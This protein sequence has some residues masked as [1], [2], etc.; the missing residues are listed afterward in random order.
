MRRSP[1]GADERCTT[2][3]LQGMTSS[4][5][6]W[7]V[8]GA[9][10]KTARVE[11][12][13]VR[14]IERAFPLWRDPSRLSSVL[15]EIARGLG[16]APV[17]A[18]TMTAE[19]ADCYATK[20]EGVAAVLDAFRSAFPDIEPWIYGVDGRFRS[21][22]AA[23]A[24]PLD[25]AAANWMASATLVARSFPD[26]IFIDVGST[27]TDVIPIFRGRVVAEG[28][29]DPARLRTGELIYTGALRTPV[30]AIARSVPVDGHRYR[31]AAEL[32]AVAADVHLWLGHIEERDYTCDTPD[33]RGRSRAE[34]AARLAR[35][36][37][38]DLGMIGNHQVDEI[39]QHVCRVQV[40][41]ITSGVRQVMRG[42]GSACP[43]VAVLAGQGAFLARRAIKD[44][45]LAPVDLAAT[46]GPDAARSTPSAAVALLLAEVLAEKGGSRTLRGPYGPQTGFED[47]RH[48]RAPS[49]SMSVSRA[50]P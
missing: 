32:F 7:D 20:R 24:Q 30:C 45:R 28:H 17:M 31:V 13:H 47:Q 50:K 11:E 43:E 16:E 2:G 1:A 33:G 4:I 49:F 6:G 3:A 34:A 12:G 36:V 18:V 35:V 22:D 46:L 40:R 41:Q 23:R 44:L 48:H 5:L 29:T 42:L 9:N 37:C 25:V 26:A 38:A 14:V 21:G 39:A 27:T 10:I 15:A 19:L 8:G